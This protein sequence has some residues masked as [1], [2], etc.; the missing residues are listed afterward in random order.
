MT[1]TTIPLFPLGTVLFPEGPLKLRI[2]EPRYVDM[3]GRC[4]REDTAFGVALIVEGREAGGPARTVEIGTTARIV[5][6]EKLSDGLLGITARGE[7]RFRIVAV[8]RQNDCL[9]IADVEWAPEEPHATVPDEFLL[10]AELL[11]RAF[12]EVRAVYGTDEPRYDDA[13][14]VGMRLAEL[15]PLQTQERQ[16]CLEMY[17]AVARLKLLRERIDIRE[18]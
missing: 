12:P 13:S 2:F 8:H 11:R 9:N 18:R 15:L 7:R 6:F 17:D 1:A 5:D 4:L 16:D 3:V 14:W 10:L